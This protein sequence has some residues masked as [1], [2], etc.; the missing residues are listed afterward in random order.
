[1]KK[2][3]IYA[4]L[5][6]L[7]VIAIMALVLGPVTAYA[8]DGLPSSWESI[9]PEGGPV[10][11]LA[12][13]PETTSTL[14]AGTTWGVYKSTDGGVTWAMS[15]EG[16]TGRISA[17]AIDSQTPTT[18]YAGSLYNGVF[19]STDGG[20][21][22][23]EC[24]TGLNSLSIKALVVDPQTPT[25]IYAGTF[26]NWGTHKSTDGGASWTVTDIVV[27]M[28]PNFRNTFVTC[29]VINPQNPSILYLGT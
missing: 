15:S 4:L 9:G 3:R 28:D 17:L 8:E 16:L 26:S 2:R 14:Y 29:L 7:V 6:G 13:D 19:K 25:T 5:S 22:W 1:M 20:E 12:I 27:G 23:V 18:L 21:N 24:N 11:T 10:L